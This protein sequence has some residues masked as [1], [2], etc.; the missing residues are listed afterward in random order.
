[1]PGI[2]GQGTTFNLPNFVGELFMATPTDTPF[3]SMIGGLTGGLPA[4]ATIFGWQGV[5]LREADKRRQ[6]A[7]G[8]TA[9]TAEERSRFN[10]TNVVEIHQEKI[11]VSYTKLAAKGQFNSSGSNHPG[12][13]G[14]TGMNP[15]V[16]E[17][18]HQ[19][20][21]AL[22]TIARDVEFSFVN[23]LHNEPG[24]NSTVRRT[25]SIREA[26]VTNVADQGTLVGNGASTIAVTG[27]ITE[28]AHGLSAGD[29]VVGRT[30]LTGATGGEIDEDQ[31]YYVSATNLAANTFSV[32]A[33]VGGPVTTFAAIGVA[34]FYSVVTLTEDHVLGLLQTVWENGGISEQE[35]A[36]VMVSGLLKRKLSDIFITSKNY[37]E[38][39][40]N[41]GGVN[42]QTFET[43]FGRLNIVLN[44]FMP[45]GS[46]QV[47][48]V[49]QCTPRFLPIPGKGFLFVEPLAKTGSAEV[50]Q[51]YGEIGLEYGNEKTHG[52]IDGITG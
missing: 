33:T 24:N 8:A 20:S 16:N 49:E 52:R 25:R 38:E 39:S 45:T 29:G 40:R 9:P 47:V 34:D 36:S 10:V 44:R 30:F 22:K 7:E 50:A 5:D 31:V 48:S 35:A 26:T 6:R 27:I 46:L 11:E 17:M 1:M 23:G 13:V 51:I 19:I 42:L 15:V 3:L 12:A 28:T 41:V 37:Q 18:D 32:S 2:T 43:D 14:L 4:D 21:M